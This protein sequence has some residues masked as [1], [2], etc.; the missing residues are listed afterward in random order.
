MD[1]QILY[2]AYVRPLLEYANQVVYSGRTKDVTL[3]ERVQRAATRMVA[4]LKSVNYETRLA[5]LDLFPLW[6]R[7]LQGDLILTYT[8]FE[9]TLANRILPLTQQTQG[10]DIPRKS[11]RS[12]ERLVKGALMELR[13]GPFVGVS[14][15]ALFVPPTVFSVYTDLGINFVFSWQ[16]DCLRIPGVLDGTRNLVYSAPTSAGKTLV[17]EIILMKHVL[18]TTSKALVI[19]PFVS[20]SREKL[21]YLQKLYTGLGVRVGGFMAGQSPPGGLSTVNVAV[22]TIEKANSMVNR[23]VEEGRLDELGLVI[24][25]ELHLIG[26]THRGYLLEL[27][28]TKLLV[29]SRRVRQESQV[30]SSLFCSQSPLATQLTRKFK[31]VQIVGMSATLPNLELLGDWLDA[32]VYTTTF[33]PVPLTELVFSRDSRTSV[34]HAYLVARSDSPQS[35]HALRSG[36]NP[37]SERLQPVST[38]LLDSQLSAEAHLTSVDEDGV[39]SLCLDTLLTGHGVLVFCPTKQWCEQLADSM[40]KHSYFLAKEDENTRPPQTDGKDDITMTTPGGIES[41]AFRLAA[42]LDRSGLMGCVERLR[43]CPAG[44]DPSLA[45]CLGYAVAFHHAGLT[46]EEREVV[47]KGFR[48]GIIRILVATSTLSSGVNLPARRVIIRTPLFHG[49]ILD[50]LCYKQMAGRAGRQGVDTSGQSILL[51]KPR[52]LPRVRQLIST[53]MPPVHSCLMDAFGGSAESTFKRALLEVIANGFIVNVAEARHYLSSTLMAKALSTATSQEDPSPARQPRRRSLRLSQTKGAITSVEASQVSPEV[54]QKLSKSPWRRDPTLSKAD[55]ILN[56][57]LSQLCDHDLIVINRCAN[58][59]CTQC[60]TAKSSN[61]LKTQIIPNC[62]Q[63]K[64]TALGRAVLSSSLGPTHGL[65]VF[66]ELDKAQRSLALDTDLHLI[67]L[68][69]PV[70]LDVGAGLDWF[71]YLEHYQSLSPADR[72]VA[73]LIGIEERFITRCAAGA[74]TTSNTNTR[75][76][77]SASN[78]ERVALHRRFY[79]ALT[80]Y[81]LVCEDGLGTVA[82]QFGVNRGLLQ[83]LQQQASTYAGMVTIFCNRL[84]WIHLERLLAG[85]QSRLFYGV[86]EELVD[87]VRLLPLVNAQRARALYA[88]GYTSVSAVANAKPRDLSSC[89][90]SRWL[91][92]VELNNLSDNAFFDLLYFIA[93][94]VIH[95]GEL[96]AHGVLQRQTIMLDDGRYVDEEEAAPLIV[97]KAQNLLQQDLVA[98]YGTHIAMLPPTNETRSSSQSSV[99]TNKTDASPNQSQCPTSVAVMRTSLTTNSEKRS[100]SPP[101]ISNELTEK[102]V[103]SPRRALSEPGVPQ[104]KRCRSSPAGRSE[105]SS[106][107]IF[108]RQIEPGFIDLSPTPKQPLTNNTQ[109]V[110]IAAPQIADPTFISQDESF[111][112]TTQLVAIVDSRSSSSVDIPLTVSQ[113]VHDQL[114]SHIPISRINQTDIEMNDTLTLSMLDNALDFGNVSLREL[115]HIS[116]S[117]CPVVKKQGLVEYLALELHSCAFLDCTPVNSRLFAVWLSSSIKLSTSRH[118]QRSDAEKGTFHREL[119]GLIHQAKSTDTVILAGDLNAQLFHISPSVCPVVKK[120]GL[121]EYLALELHSCAFLDCTPVN[122]RLF[123]VWLSSSIKLSTS[124]HKQRPV[125]CGIPD[126]QTLSPYCSRILENAVLPT[127]VTRLNDMLRSTSE[128]VFNIVEVTRTEPLWHTFVGDFIEWIRRFDKCSS[129]LSSIAVQPC[130]MMGS[131]DLSILPNAPIPCTWLSGPAGHPSVGGGVDLNSNKHPLALTLTGLA[132]SSQLLLPNTVFWIE[133]DSSGDPQKVQRALCLDGLRSIFTHLAQSRMML[134][135]WDA[136]WWFRVARD[137]LGFG[138]LSV[139]DPATAGWL[140][141]P[142]QGRPLLSSEVL[143]LNPNMQELIEQLR[144]AGFNTDWS[145]LVP[146]DSKEPSSICPPNRMVVL[147]GPFGLSQHI[148]IAAT[149][150]Y[151]LAQWTDPDLF[152]MTEVPEILL[153]LELPCQALLARVES[154]GFDWSNLVPADSKEPSSICPPNRM[155]VLNGPFGLSQH[156]SIAATHCYLL[157][158]WTDPDL[159]CMTEVPEILLQLELPCQALLARVESTGFASVFFAHQKT[160]TPG[161]ISPTYDVYTATGRIVSCFPNI[162]AVPKDI[163]IDYTQIHTRKPPSVGTFCP[164]A[165]SV[166]VTAEDSTKNCIS[167]RLLTPYVR[168]RALTSSGSSKPIFK[169]RRPVY[170]A[171]FNVRTLK[172]TGQQADLAFTLDSLGIYVCRLSETGIQDASTV[173][174]ITAPSVSTRF[175]L[176]TSGDPEAAAAGCAGF[177]I[178]LSY[179]AEVS[180][181]DRIPTDSHLCAIRLATSVK[182]SHKREV[183]RCLF[184]ESAY[185]PTDCS[186]DAVKDR[187]YKALNALPR[188]AK[189]SDI[190]VVAG[191]LSAQVGRTTR[192]GELAIRRTKEMEEAQKAGNTRRLFQLIRAT[193]PRKPPVSETIKHQNGTTISNKEECLDRWAEYF[194]QQ[195]SWPQADT[196][197]GPKREVEPWTVNVEPP[198]ASEVYDCICSLK[199]HRAPGPDDLLP[200]LFKDGGEVLSQRLSDLFA[201]IWKEESVPDTWGESMI[202][203]SLTPI[204]TRLLASVVLPRLTVAREILTREQKA[205]FRPGRGCVDQIFT[206]HQVLEQRHTYKRPTILVFLDFRGAF[207]LVQLDTLANQCPPRKFL[208]IIRS[209]YSQTSGHVIRPRRAFQACSGGILVSADFCQLE[210]RLLAHFSRDTDLLKLLSIDGSV[211]GTDSSLPPPPEQDAFRKLAA[212]WLRLSSTHEVSSNQRQQAKQICYALI[213]GMGVQGLASQL[214]VPEATAQRLMDSFMYSYPVVKRSLELLFSNPMQSLLHVELQDIIYALSFSSNLKGIQRFISDTIQSAHRLGYVSTLRGRLRLLPA[215]GDKES[216]NSHA[217]PQLTVPLLVRNG[218]L[219]TQQYY[220]IAKAERQA[221]NTVIQGSAAEIAKAAMLEVDEVLM[222]NDWHDNCRLVLHEHDELVYEVVPA[223]LGP[224][225]GSLIRHT[226]ARTSQTHGLS[227]PLPV[228]LTAGRNWSEL[229]EVLWPNS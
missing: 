54:P 204:V 80:L 94:S 65:V 226:L 57:C 158:Q 167:V 137:L 202:G 178:V 168:H 163:V 215:L 86:A 209:L 134:V 25:D 194:E 183:D 229:E 153:Q 50:Y 136:K 35:H 128:S 69:T 46:V 184:I 30:D 1:F 141:D 152:C 98:V 198:T 221:V 212:H 200:A 147:N 53:G 188:R 45:R 49:K 2:G 13:P 169:L 205:G 59:D 171:A 139:F 47:E 210:L 135:A 17:A 126:S 142:D 150:C 62:Y 207:D 92:T 48:S 160:T 193:G 95:S 102:P 149:H 157:A 7:R 227:V 176:R 97:Q 187:L 110:D 211:D 43:Q 32:A 58:I 111:V 41:I 145:N 190:V 67:Y 15:N 23:L 131:P 93:V 38:P 4:G 40:A 162:Q 165:N 3:I 203:F 174:E 83:S 56:L 223:S 11:Q 8:L 219:Q 100:P 76:G 26:D 191:N 192:E 189:S 105:V 60:H 222:S 214:N 90:W 39:F 120:Q 185:A 113:P 140:R 72:R 195:L 179:W 201:C 159:F 224:V 31:G 177:G 148:S 124:R 64:P 103:L 116:P 71:R 70:Y 118:K 28:L 99:C 143:R 19:L 42:R 79:T 196:H 37:G 114:D 104:P 107:I 20:V 74:S 84:G 132:V 52:D 24:V 112:L 75:Q 156:I 217:Q 186:F 108:D 6:Y 197:L 146:A 173:I 36:S 21:F 213:Y 225:L 22:C 85:F 51:C 106:K 125:D 29:H 170:V 154:T 172:Q 33:R 175:R 133:L 109:A 66:E 34:N 44:L 16:G 27:L 161:R 91:A 63:L 208:N 155:V 5:M 101:F 127:A 144:L 138:H 117:V 88:G 166:A 228:K 121:V 61:H 220:S 9:Q 82:E 199:R 119:S 115:F 55:R 180:F 77:A 123:A 182:E 68:L 87:L 12:L 73:D 122:S 10:G 81:R 129:H 218:P 216:G 130:W 181:L 18:E 89:G 151:L 96:S 206:L 164:A 14:D 78:S